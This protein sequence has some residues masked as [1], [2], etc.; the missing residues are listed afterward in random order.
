ML[1]VRILGQIKALMTLMLVLFLAGCA[2]GQGDGAGSI[3]TG[4]EIA[5]HSAADEETTALTGYG[6][7]PRP[8]ES[9]LSYG[10]Q[11][12]KAS[13][14]TYCWAS[15]ASAS[16]GSAIS[17]CVD[18]FDI[19]IPPEQRSLAVPSRSQMVFRYGGKAYR[20]WR[21][22]KST[23]ATSSKRSAIWKT[24]NIHTACCRLTV[25][26]SKGPSPPSCHGETTLWRCTLRSHL[27]NKSAT[28]SASWWSS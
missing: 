23:R 7:I 17:G 12:V 22:L 24:C 10:G 8:P 18:Y 20:I 6:G 14:G 13:L 21:K 26:G 27:I 1:E 16:A 5:T 19:P 4:K 11:E 2:A 25:R 9:T 15:G 28:I 3:T